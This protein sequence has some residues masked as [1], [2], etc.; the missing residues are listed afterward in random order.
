[1][2][3]AQPIGGTRLGLCLLEGY[4]GLVCQGS[5]CHLFVHR[6]IREN[7]TIHFNIGFLQPVNKAAVA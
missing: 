4:F 2:R 5:K 3:P 1:M 6:Q 7:T